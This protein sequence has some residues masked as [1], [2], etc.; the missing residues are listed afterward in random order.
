ML[1]KHD[2]EPQVATKFNLLKEKTF[3]RFFSLNFK[4]LF[5]VCYIYSVGKH[6]FNLQY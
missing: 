6:H 3:L 5:P 2:Y 4:L 1:N